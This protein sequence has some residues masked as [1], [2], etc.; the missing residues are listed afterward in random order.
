MNGLG[1]TSAAVGFNAAVGGAPGT[2]F[3]LPG[4]L[5]PGTFL[6]T[7]TAPLITTTN[8]GM[9]G[10]LLFQV[11]NGRVVVPPPGGV[12]PEPA[13]W[14]LLIAGFGLVGAFARRR[15]LVSA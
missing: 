15:R 5:V 6:D 7:G 9:P 11:R 13:T 8:I 4:S 14:A 1:G 2:F 3:E 10:R 12:I